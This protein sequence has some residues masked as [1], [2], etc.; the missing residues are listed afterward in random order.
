[1]DRI[2]VNRLG[3]SHRISKEGC[4][5]CY[6]VGLRYKNIGILVVVTNPYSSDNESSVAEAVMKQSA[7]VVRKVKRFMKREL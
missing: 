4:E 3:A 5:Y 7:E 2:I 6:R 1:M